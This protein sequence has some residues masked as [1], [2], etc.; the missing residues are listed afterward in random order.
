MN[1]II[2][3][4]L[5]AKSRRNV[6]ARNRNHL[7]LRGGPPKAGRR[8]NLALACHCEG[9]A[10]SNLM[11]LLHFVRNDIKLRSLA[12]AI[13]M[14]LLSG[15]LVFP[16][17]AQQ[18]RVLVA[19]EQAYSNMIGNASF[20]SWSNGTGTANS[21]PDA[22]TKEGTPTTYDKLTA[23]KRFGSLSAQVVVNAASQGITQSVNVEPNITYTV[24]FYYKTGAGSFAFTVTGTIS[25]TLSGNTGLSS[26]NW[27]YKSFTFTTGAATTSITL[28]LLSEGASDVFK[29]DGIMLSRGSLAPAFVEKAFTDTGDQTV[30][31]D[32]KVQD[33]DG[34]DNILLDKDTGNIT[35]TGALSAAAGSST[36]G[37]LQINGNTISATN[38]SGVAIYDNASLGLFVEDGGNVGIG[39][40]TPTKK[41]EVN[42]GIKCGGSTSGQSFM[43]SGLVVNEAGGAAAT[44]D[45]R[46]E[47]D[48]NANA[49]VVDASANEVL[50]GVNLG[51]TGVVTWSDGGS[52]NANTAYTDRLKWDGGDTDLNVTTAKASLSYG[53][54]A[55]RNAEDTLTNGSN[56]PDGAAVMSYVTGLGYITDDTSVPKN[57]LTNSGALSFDWADD[58]VS[59]TL[60]INNGLLYAPTS[61]N[62]GIGVASPTA[63]KLQIAG[64]TAVR[65]GDKLIVDSDDTGDSYIAHNNANDY[66]SLYIDGFECARIKKK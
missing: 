49:F 57:N 3:N 36:L 20:E 62:V 11:R 39:T 8:S 38:D 1:T 18:E 37:N 46:V 33:V 29:L 26:A 61:G 19:Q 31:G 32:I 22:W 35:L 6:I 16:S 9:G 15:A 30:Y 55:D 50:V 52:A 63:A 51:V 12:M 54:A 40:T 60:T 48:T 43:A 10:R 66:I 21:V 24:G 56:L 7:S 13:S 53:T 44:D 4:I 17:Y 27:T 25:P 28:N 59:D 47:T 2:T 65:T 5:R 41:L 14:L 58:E 23:D 34:S 45:F 42:G 64:N